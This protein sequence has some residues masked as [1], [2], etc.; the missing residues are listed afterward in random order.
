M[1]DID[2]QAQAR[3]QS[4]GQVTGIKKNWVFSLEDI[5]QVPHEYLIVD[6]TKV[7]AVIKSGMREIPGLKIYQETTRSGR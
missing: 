7:N 3:Q 5:K 4:I 1:Q 6:H 2:M